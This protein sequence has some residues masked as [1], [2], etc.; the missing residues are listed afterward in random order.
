[1]F[2]S[3]V[4]GV[5]EEAKFFGISSILEQLEEMVKVL[6]WKF[7]V[8]HCALFTWQENYPSLKECTRKDI[9]RA[10]P[11]QP[12][13]WPFLFLVISFVESL[14]WNNIFQNFRKR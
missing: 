14:E 6:V 1:M 9:Q 2:W 12:K 7:Y 11:I 13:L 3:F 5:L 8:C 10:L 4:T